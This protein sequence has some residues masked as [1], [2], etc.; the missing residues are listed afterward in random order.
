MDR[1]FGKNGVVRINN[2]YGYSCHARGVMAL[3]DGKII[4]IAAFFV[5]EVISQLAA[6]IKLLPNGDRD[7]DFNNGEPALV[8]L[9]SG[10]LPC[11]N[12]RRHGRRQ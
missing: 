4:L 3:D 7:P 5:A 12:D 9:R 1:S 8:D 10:G 6:A 2:P 11:S